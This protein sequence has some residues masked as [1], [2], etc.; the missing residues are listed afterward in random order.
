MLHEVSS[1]MI[2]ITSGHEQKILLESFVDEIILCNAS[3]VVVG[4]GPLSF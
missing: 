4:D 1:G 3:Q 2:Y